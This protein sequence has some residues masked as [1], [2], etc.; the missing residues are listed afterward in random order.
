MENAHLPPYFFFGA[1][2]FFSKRSIRV[3]NFCNFPPQFATRRL[4]CLHSHHGSY[5]F[6]PL[7]NMD[8][9]F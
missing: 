2:F 7:T 8:L 1:N 4:R 9:A 6:N 5:Y 3:R